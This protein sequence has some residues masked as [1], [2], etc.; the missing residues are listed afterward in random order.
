[1][2]RHN[3]SL[4][5]RRQNALA[6]NAFRISTLTPMP[7]RE[8]KRNANLE[9]CLE[10]GLE[11]INPPSPPIQPG[12]QSGKPVVSRASRMSDSVP[13]IAINRC[14]SSYCLATELKA[15]CEFGQPTRELVTSISHTDG[16]WNVPTFVNEFWTAR[17][18]QA[19]SL[20]EISYRACFKPQLP[21]FF[22]ERLSQPG[23]AIY[24]PFMGRGTTP[25]EA[26]QLGRVAF[27]NDINPLSVI[28]TKPR[29]NPP[30]LDQI[31][32]RL[33]TIDLTD[34]ADMP[35]DLLVFYHPETLRGISA[36][37]R[38]F[39]A[40]RGAGSFDD[41]DAWLEMVSL[42]R[43]TGHSSG[44][45]SVYTLPPNQAVSVKSQIKINAKR[46]QTPPRRD[47]PGI[48]LKK[49]RQLLGDCSATVRKTLASVTNQAQLFTGSAAAT[50]GI[51]DGSVTLIVT[52]PPFLDIVQY[53]DD[54]WL[55]CWFVGTDSKSVQITTP[56]KVD[57]WQATM[58]EIFRE[59][60]RV[61]KPGGHVA[62]EVGEVHSGKTK[63]EETVVPCGVAAGLDP[64]LI[65]INDQ[66][67]TKTANCWGVDNMTKG[68]NTNRIVVF[69]KS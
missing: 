39:A 30:T 26:A 46:N 17:Q 58:T 9:D 5:G 49:S 18:R 57:V 27:G 22:I 42:N 43:L 25:V 20:H 14:P 59:L 67:F 15:F 51:P 2:D 8:K 53:A 6:V 61:L 44:F 69:R 33:R 23:E 47:I 28:M 12:A 38:Y 7:L 13:R 21:R 68:T 19:S 60:G 16:V 41:V 64:L 65:M 36:L 40:R 34:A 1:M 52:S 3:G 50:K 11:F 45:F 55:R 63:L 35:E 10:L 62:F 37:K 24:D 4:E 56:K 54:N 29:L 48:L 66:K 32:A 31:H